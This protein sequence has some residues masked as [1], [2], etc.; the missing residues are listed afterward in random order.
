MKPKVYKPPHYEARRDDR[1]SA[2]RRGYGQ[3]WRK[4]RVRY[5][6]ANPYCHDCQA[7]GRRTTATEIHH[8][9]RLADRPDLQ[10]EADNLLPLCK[11]C[12]QRRTRRGE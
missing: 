6:A 8:V 10:F 5:L 3:R 1:P 9:M 4:F 7:A 2:T 12:H 11:T